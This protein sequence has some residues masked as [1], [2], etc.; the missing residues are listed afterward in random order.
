MQ[1]LLKPLGLVGLLVVSFTLV[2]NVEA[3]TVEV[4][5]A[6]YNGDPFNGG[7]QVGTTIFDDSTISR[8][9]YEDDN[10]PLADA[11]YVV[12]SPT[13]A[14]GQTNEAITFEIVDMGDS[15]TTITI[16]Q[17]GV[18]PS[19][20]PSLAQ[21]IDDVQTAFEGNLGFIL[22]ADCGG[23]G[24]YAVS[25]YLLRPGETS[26]TF[27]N[28]EGATHVRMILGEQSLTAAVRPDFSSSINTVEIEFPEGSEEYIPLILLPLAL[29]QQN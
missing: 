21:V 17:D 1:A 7:E 22:F 24:C 26:P 14:M 19:E 11:T 25:H 23:E 9:L 6:F 29:Q 28:Y 12:V 13:A 2:Q 5:A 27:V 18:D 15:K 4:Q 3:Q 10:D 20:S 8:R 16:A